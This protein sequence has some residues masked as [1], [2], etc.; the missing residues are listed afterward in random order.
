[1]FENQLKAVKDAEK[2]YVQNK[3]LVVYHPDP[4]TGKNSLQAPKESSPEATQND[5]KSMNVFFHRQIV[6]N[7]KLF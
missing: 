1:M 6:I 4:V 5:S 2:K 3:Q 7:E